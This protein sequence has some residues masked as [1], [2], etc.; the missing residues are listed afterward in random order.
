MSVARSPFVRGFVAP[1][2]GLLWLVRN[3]SAWGLALV[4]TIVFLLLLVL[5]SGT[6]IVVAEKLL[7]TGQTGDLLGI[8]IHLV[9]WLV[10]VLVAAVLSL[11]L[12]KP[13]SGVALEALATRR[14]ADL[15]LPKRPEIGAIEG[16]LRSLRVTLFGLAV[17]LPLVLAL[18]VLTLFVPVL[19]IVTV[20][21]KL[22]LTCTMLAWDVV[23]Y[24]LSVRGAGVRSRLA[25]FSENPQMAVGM[26][27]GLALMFCV[28]AAG[29]LLIGAGVAGATKLVSEGGG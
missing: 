22:L 6:G 11:A 20:P 5:L 16:M 14:E 3:P 23:D 28:P 18:A 12:A 29:L 4:P 8:V 7:G 13:L 24:P 9:A 26:G 15:G 27:A 10:A 21:L 2:E 1:W 25:W 19:S 17:T